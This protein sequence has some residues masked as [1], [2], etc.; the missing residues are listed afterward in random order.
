MPPRVTAFLFVDCLAAGNQA[1]F[2]SALRHLMLPALV[3][4]WVIM[5]LI[6]RITRA[7]LLEV[8]QADY[9]RTAPSKG[10]REDLVVGIH[11][12]RNAMIPVVTVVGLSFAGLLSGA[13]STRAGHPSR[14]TT[15]SARP[16]VAPVTSSCP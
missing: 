15:P 6:A 8:L 13:E 2:W 3:L 11:A 9:V 12:L 16:T 14:L 10:L 4:G 1:L 5:G 7:S